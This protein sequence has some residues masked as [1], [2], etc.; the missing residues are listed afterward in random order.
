MGARG[1]YHGGMREPGRSAW[2]VDVA[3]LAGVLAWLAATAAIALAVMAS[4]SSARVGPALH[5]L[6]LDTVFAAGDVTPVAVAPSQ[7]A[8]DGRGPF[9]LWPGTGVEAAPGEL[10]DMT[11][12]EARARLATAFV[13]RRMQVGAGWTASLGDARL[14]AD[15]DA[16]ERAV[17]HPLAEAELGRALLRL[18]LDDGSRAADWPTQAARNPGAPVQ[19]LVGV[20]VTLPVD[21]VQGAGTRLVG[22]RIVAGLANRLAEG[23]ADAVRAAMGN[24]QLEGALE[25]ALA[26]PVRQAWRAALAAA[27]MPRDE[28]LGE[29][30]QQAQSVFAAAAEAVDPLAGAWAGVDL[31]GATPE[32][33]RTRTLAALAERGYEAGADG[34]AAALATP[35]ARGRVAAAAD[36]ID[37]FAAAAHRRYLVWGWVAGIAAAL[38]LAILV[39]VQQGRARALA[40]AVVLLVAGAPWA[41]GWWWWQGRAE[42]AV[43]AAAAV[44]TSATVAGLPGAA[45]AW[46]HHLVAASASAAAEATLA[47]AVAAS[48][49]G[50][51]LLALALLAG[52]AAWVRP[53]RRRY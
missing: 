47:P 26:G 20:F 34:L 39:L 31:E 12:A 38:L 42:G 33:A 5:A 18:G 19:P 40:P 17:L 1:G 16:W 28:E 44:P 4:L 50:A 23:G 43:D 41:V 2:Q 49:A 45:E 52:L 27:W 37:A 15:L 36:W 48:A 25:T 10:P 24:A 29:R 8:Y 9:E 35:D 51:L 53:R 46:F 30:L 6:L 13:E 32:E 3:W 11:V 21:A 7:V 22:D 14:A